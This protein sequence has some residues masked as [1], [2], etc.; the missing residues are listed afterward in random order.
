M[1]R[2]HHRVLR[3]RHRGTAAARRPRHRTADDGAEP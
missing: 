1:G 3:D 2:P